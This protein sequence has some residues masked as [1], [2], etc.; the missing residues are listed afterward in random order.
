MSIVIRGFCIVSMMVAMVVT[1]AC[2]QTYVRKVRRASPV[3][4]VES[5]PKAYSAE[6]VASWYGPGFH[7]RRTASG[8]R[9]NTHKLTAAHR[10]LPFGTKVLV[11]NLANDK[12][13]ELEINDR[14]PA[15]STNRLIDLSKAAAKEL[16]F[17]SAGTTKVRV[18]VIE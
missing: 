10:T 2:Q 16:G 12:T 18:E 13:V 17:A 4:A 11:T 1:T 6:G 8:K 15:K 7:G 5:T 14:G 9:F 3:E